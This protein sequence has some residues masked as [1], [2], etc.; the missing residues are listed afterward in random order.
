MSHLD[1][2][3][4]TNPITNDNEKAIDF[5]YANSRV[6]NRRS[7][8]LLSQLAHHRFSTCVSTVRIH[9]KTLHYFLP[10]QQYFCFCDR[11]KL[12]CVMRRTTKRELEITLYPRGH[13]HCSLY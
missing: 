7:I 8:D 9:A 11:Y 12:V 6:D 13:R 4:R 2:W 3:I 5:V 1:L 10:I